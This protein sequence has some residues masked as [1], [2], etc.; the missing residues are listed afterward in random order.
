LSV[1]VFSHGSYTRFAWESGSVRVPLGW[2]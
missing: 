2:R 1:Y